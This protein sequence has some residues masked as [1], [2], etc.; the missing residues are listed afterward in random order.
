MGHESVHY[1]IEKYYTYWRNFAKWKCFQ[2]RMV[3]WADDILHNALVE[4]LLKTDLRMTDDLYIKNFVACEIK[5][6]TYDSKRAKRDLFDIDSQYEDVPECAGPSYDR[7]SE[8]DFGRFREVSC[9]TRC[10]DF[11]VPVN[12]GFYVTPKAGW[13]SGWVHSY[14]LK[15]RRYAYWQYSAFVGSRCKGEI[16]KRLKTSNSR[17]EAYVGLMDYNRQIIGWRPIHE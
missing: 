13:I 3:S 17:H 1:A 5:H 9:N 12:N 7:M 14:E 6:R 2:M 10:D 16:P 4:L 11:I 8:E 15:G